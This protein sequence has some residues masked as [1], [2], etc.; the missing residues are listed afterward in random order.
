MA[1]KRRQAGRGYVQVLMMV[2]RWLAGGAD[3]QYSAEAYNQA[4]SPGRVLCWRCAVLCAVH[5][6]QPQRLRCM[7]LEYTWLAGVL[8]GACVCFLCFWGFNSYAV[9]VCF[10]VRSVP[11]GVGGR[12]MHDMHERRPTT[13]LLHV[14]QGHGSVFCIF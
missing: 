7:P 13:T 11:K 14:M 4:M 9:G 6:V 5:M 2:L 1:A 12:R 10:S 3:V 8:G